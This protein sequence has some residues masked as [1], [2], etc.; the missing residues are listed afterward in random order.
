M[1]L[2]DEYAE[3][4]DRF[5]ILAFHDAT[6]KTLDELDRKLARVVASRWGGKALPFPVL[7]DA[8]GST[9]RSFGIRAYPTAVLIDPRGRVVKGDAEATLAATLAGLAK[10][11]PGREAR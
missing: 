2:Y 11:A 5:E 9:V 1:K 7:L 3:L 10:A 8:T 6:A 4:R